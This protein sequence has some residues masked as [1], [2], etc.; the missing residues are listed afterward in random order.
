MQ[1]AS[2]NVEKYNNFILVNFWQSLGVKVVNIVFAKSK[3]PIIIPIIVSVNP[4]L[5][6]NG[7][8]RG[9]IIEYP[10]PLIKFIRNK[11]NVI[12]ILSFVYIN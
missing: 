1:V 6:P 5:T 8:N 11:T 3:I 10:I 4:I 12:F 7:G 9:D 2:P